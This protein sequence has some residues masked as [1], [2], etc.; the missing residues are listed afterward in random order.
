MGREVRTRGQAATGYLVSNTVASYINGFIVSNP[1]L[2]EQTE[3]VLYGIQF[4]F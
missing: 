4:V 3:Q 1:A 2:N